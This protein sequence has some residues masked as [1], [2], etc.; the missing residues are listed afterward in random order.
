VGDLVD[1]GY[2]ATGGS[3]QLAAV[4]DKPPVLATCI[5]AWDERWVRQ[6]HVV[7]SHD[8]VLIHVADVEELHFVLVFVAPQVQGESPVGKMAVGAVEG[9]AVGHVATV[10]G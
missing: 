4:T 5:H 9:L 2:T 8:D 1:D 10:T 7:C 6:V 3:D